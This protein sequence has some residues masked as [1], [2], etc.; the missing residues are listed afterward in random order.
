MACICGI[1][2]HL[3]THTATPTFATTVT[4]E[5]DVPLEL[6]ECS[7]IEAYGDNADLCKNYSEKICK[8][9]NGLKGTLFGKEKT[10]IKKIT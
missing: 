7:D 5:N 3:T 6:L 4:L 10:V 1:N 9:M 8:N 2:K